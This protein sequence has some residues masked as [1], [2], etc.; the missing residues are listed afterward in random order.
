[1]ANMLTTNH[2][3]FEKHEM[4]IRLA[5]QTLSSSVANAIEFLDKSIKLRNFSGSNGTVLF[6]RTIDRL[7]DLL[8]S[9]NPWPKGFKAPLRLSS[10]DTWQEIYYQQQNIYCHY[11]LQ[12]LRLIHFLH[13]NAKTFV[14]GF[15]TFIKS[16]ISMA[17]QML[18]LSTNPFQ[19]L[20]TY[21]FARD[22]TELLFSCYYCIQ[23]CQLCGLHRLQ[24]PYTTIPH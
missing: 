22:H 10:K 24:Q 9:R 2:L 8:N 16:T 21:K 11:K 15:D 14:I 20:L 7:F 5:A 13:L 17:T 19:Y 4:N 18:S 3:K 6:I 23:K 1:M 12:H